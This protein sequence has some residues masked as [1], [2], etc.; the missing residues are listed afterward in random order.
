MAG[1]LDSTPMVCL[2]C[3]LLFVMYGLKDCSQAEVWVSDCAGGKDEMYQC[4]EPE[5]RLCLV[6]VNR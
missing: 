1:L 4:K 5:T 3:W 2:I 6:P